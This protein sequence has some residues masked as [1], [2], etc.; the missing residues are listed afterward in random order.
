[1]NWP[2]SGGNNTIAARSGVQLV[3]CL[4]NLDVWG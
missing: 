4:A 1:L 2:K 3:W